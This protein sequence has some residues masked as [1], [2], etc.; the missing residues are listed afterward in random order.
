MKQGDVCYLD[1]GEVPQV[2]HIRLLGCQI[3]GAL[4]AIV[5]PAPDEDAYEEEMSATN[6]DLVAFTYG[7]PGLGSPIPPGLNHA[8]VYGFRALTAA[9]YEQL[10]YVYAA[11]IRGARGLPPSPVPPFL[12]LVAQGRRGSSNS[13]RWSSCC[14][15]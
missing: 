14:S 1:Y 2:I 13:F 7:G 12:E 8:R 15:R 10:I 4:W 3:D 11:G 6:S 5:T 9:R